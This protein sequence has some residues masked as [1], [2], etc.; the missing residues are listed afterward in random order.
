MGILTWVLLGLV[1]GLLAEFLMPG[2]AKGGIVVTIVLGIVGALLG[3]F[4]SS[5]FLGVDVTGFN[6][7]SILI[8]VGGAVL[9]LFIYGWLRRRKIV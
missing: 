3:G 1:A 6:L 5:Q 2:K 7:N 9:V 4:L 8:A